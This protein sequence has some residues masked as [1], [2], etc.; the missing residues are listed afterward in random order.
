MAK[1]IL[2]PAESQ[3]RLGIGH[4]RFYEWIKT[5]KLKP[6]VQLGPK[7]VGHP[8]DEIDEV[9]DALIAERD[10]KLAA[11]GNKP[12]KAA[13]RKQPATESN[14][15]F[16]A[17]EESMPFLRTLLREQVASAKTERE[18]REIVERARPQIAELEPN[19]RVQLMSEITQDLLRFPKDRE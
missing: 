15:H 18:A 12:P 6:P 1:R 14:A 5:G 11:P 19:A 9:V 16:R 3:A 13:D 17:T 10:R 4:T 8:E 2:R 7:S